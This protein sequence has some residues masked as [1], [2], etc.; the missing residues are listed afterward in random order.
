MKNLVFAALFITICIMGCKE[1]SGQ[2][3]SQ[4]ITDSLGATATGENRE[5]LL[6]EYADV[7]EASAML[8]AGD[9][10]MAVYALCQQRYTEQLSA[11]KQEAEALGAKFAVTI[12]SPEIGEA[13]TASTKKGI[14]FIMD[15]AKKLG[16]EAHD[17][18]T[19]MA[20]YTPQQITQMPVDGHWS[21][22]GAKIVAG[23]YQSVIT[24][25]S[26]HRATK[27]FTAGERTATFGDLEPGQN[28]ALDGG[29]DIPYQLIT[30]SQGLR[31]EYDLTFPKTKQRIL[32]IGDSQIYSPFLDNNQIPT[33]VLQQQF[34]DKE[35]I[36]AGFVGYTIDDHVSLLSQ[37]AKY[38]EPD[39]IILVT[40]PN[41]IGDFYFSQRNRMS[42]SKK[43]YAP[44]ATELALHKQLF[45]KG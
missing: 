8:N 41:D 38:T 25:N 35:I 28:V 7:P 11:L 4:V 27:T 36:N 33:A 12:L 16:I 22:A 30:N 34:A 44:T 2:E 5:N 13:V 20:K 31:M 39:I 6:S 9:T 24:A 23:L 40:N 14:P 3:D 18:T 10:G 42:R 1:K 29:K 19:P 15:A 21:V 17:L 45:P 32:F 26:N 37:K 43:A